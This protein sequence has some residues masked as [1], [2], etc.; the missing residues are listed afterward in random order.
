MENLFK[1]TGPIKMQLAQLGAFPDIEHPKVLWV[2][3]KND[4]QKII[5][6]V[7][8]LEKGLGEIGFKKE[9]QLV[10]PKIT[11]GRTR[12]PRILS[13]LSKAVSNYSLPIKLT[14]TA[15]NIILYKST[16]TSAGPIYEALQRIKLD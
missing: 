8:K 6:L 16:L 13:A 12:S 2:G 15:E 1:N 3:L 10:H 7:S 9:E 14:Q 5:Q 11:I 4:E